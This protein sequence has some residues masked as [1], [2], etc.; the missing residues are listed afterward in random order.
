MPQ[1]SDSADPT[2]DSIREAARRISNVTSQTPVRTSSRLSEMHGAPVLLK[3][4]T[5]QPT[6]SFKV[7]GAANAV[8]RQRET[9]G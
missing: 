2:L 4:E 7:R 1:V 6:G 8:L 9:R 3:L 5:V